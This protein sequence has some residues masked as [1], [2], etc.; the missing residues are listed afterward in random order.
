MPETAFTVF[1]PAAGSYRSFVD[2]SD[3]ITYV[4]V[5]R[6]TVERPEG[7][8]DAP[9]CVAMLETIDDLG[10]GL[11]KGA[12]FTVG[13][14]NLANG[15]VVTLDGV[16]TWRCTP[17]VWEM[18]SPEESAR[19]PIGAETCPP[20]GPEVNTP[21]GAEECIRLAARLQVRTLL[22][23][24][25][26]EAERAREYVS[27]WAQAFDRVERDLR[28]AT[29]A[30]ARGINE[31]FQDPKLFQAEFK[32]L[33]PQEKHA[34][35]QA[36]RQRPEVYPLAPIRQAAPTEGAVKR[37]ATLTAEAGF[38][39]LNAV[40]AREQ[41]RIE[42][43][44]ALGISASADFAVLRDACREKLRAA[45]VNKAAAVSQMAALGKVPSRRELGAA[46]AMLTETERSRVLQEVPN[47]SRLL[48]SRARG[49][50]G[51]GHSL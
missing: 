12:R 18:L 3:K 48:G 30:F 4:A 46:F 7:K 26:R 47:V 31:T 11:G 36:L 43:A 41:V 28:T 33:A 22:T 16:G 32:R 25:V 50:A 49:L 10:S 6:G 38:R 29:D 39:Y 42:G 34:T 17:L 45:D 44:R 51:A 8:V 21:S 1:I 9:V 24:S 15:D 13:G 14:R 20:R 27:G 23:A 40:A 5:H 37:R 19:F 2:R 35:L